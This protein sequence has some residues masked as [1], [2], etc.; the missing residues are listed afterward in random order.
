ML[1]FSMTV[2]KLIAFLSFLC[3]S[4]PLV[5]VYLKMVQKIKFFQFQQHY[6]QKDFWFTDGLASRSHFVQ[7]SYD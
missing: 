4:S 1:S 6:L 7:H 3:E 2:L 5:S